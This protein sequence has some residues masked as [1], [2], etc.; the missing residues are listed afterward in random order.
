MSISSTIDLTAPD[1]SVITVSQLDD[2]I[3]LAKTE[4]RERLETLIDTSAAAWTDTTAKEIL[5]GLSR[6]YTDTS[7]PTAN[8]GHTLMDGQV[9]VKTDADNTAAIKVYYS[10]AW[11]EL[12]IGTANLLADAVTET[13]IVDGAV[14]LA[15]LATAPII[16]DL[17]TEVTD[18]TD[19]T[20]TTSTDKQIKTMQLVITPNSS[21]SVLIFVLQAMVGIGGSGTNRAELKIVQDPSGTPVTI[22]AMKSLKSAATNSSHPMTLVGMVTG[23][24]GAT[25]FQPMFNSDNNSN[26]ATIA[27]TDATTRFQC[28]ELKT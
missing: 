6:V 15:K 27:G 11:N 13:E 20:N 4:V 16:T 21:A 28:I 23:I 14:T 24:S 17:K 10:S 1:G 18:S 8:T 25:T 26:T 2:A 7:D 12:Q 9:Y 22:A 3:R 5:Q 19:D